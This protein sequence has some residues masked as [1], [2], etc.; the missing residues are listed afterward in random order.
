MFGLTALAVIV[1]L[2]L[3]VGVVVPRRARLLV[4]T[5]VVIFGV[6]PWASW[7]GHSHWDR[8][9]WVPFTGTFRLR[10]I[11]LNVLFYVPVGFFFVRDGLWRWKGTLAGAVGYG[12]LL[13][14]MTEFT[15]VFGHGR[16]PS[17][18]DVLTNTSGAL[19][20]ALLVNVLTRRVGDRS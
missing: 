6:V 2:P 7:V 4:W 12:L 1:T 10:D 17:M 16:F 20:G 13:S 3:L 19:A 8:I 15:Q 18:T 9:E 14:L 11:V 5:L